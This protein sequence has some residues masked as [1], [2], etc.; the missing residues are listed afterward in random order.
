MAGRIC[1]PVHDTG[2]QLV[3]YAGR[4]PGEDVPEDQERYK[5]PK[6]FQKSRVL[7]NLHRVRDAEHVVLVE[8]TG[9]R[10]GSTPWACRSWR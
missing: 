6:N 4:W 5:L 1:I 9:R 7:F 8:G 10:S 3:A 2:G